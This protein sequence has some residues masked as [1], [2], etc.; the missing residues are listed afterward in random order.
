[1]LRTELVKSSQNQEHLLISSKRWA[2]SEVKEIEK[3][4][5]FQPE[6]E[7]SLLTNYSKLPELLRLR[8]SPKLRALRE[9][10]NVF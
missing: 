1:M 3:R 4:S 6:A 5:N 2:E 9:L 10:L 8:V 7:T